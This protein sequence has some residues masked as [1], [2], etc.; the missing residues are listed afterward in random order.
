MVSGATA[1]ESRSGKM[2]C[3]MNILKK[4]K[5]FSALNK[6]EIIE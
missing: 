5:L 4:K 6:F 2:G 3:K 1:R